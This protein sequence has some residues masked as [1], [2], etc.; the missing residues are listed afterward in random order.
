[1]FEDYTEAYKEVDPDTGEE[2]VKFT[3]DIMDSQIYNIP[4]L[5]WDV[6]L[7][8][9][10]IEYFMNSF[11]NEYEFMEEVIAERIR[12]VTILDAK[13]YNT[14][15]RSRNFII[16]EDGEIIDTVVCKL[17]FDIY[18]VVGTNMSYAS[19]T[20]KNFI[21]E[22]VETVNELGQNNLYVSNLIR[23]IENNFDFV[24]HIRFNAINHYDSSYQTVKNKT[25]ELKDLSVEERRWYVPEFL[26]C[27]VDQITLNEHYRED[28][29]SQS[30]WT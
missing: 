17:N 24:D 6:A 12:N 9:D 27:D 18:Y 11:Y 25:L 13:F 8:E 7:D 28:D 29:R 1:M 20:I 5:K 23:K 10:N 22:T 19:E 21:K 14:Y 16:G 4:M 15:G 2:V 30:L 26:V 3:H